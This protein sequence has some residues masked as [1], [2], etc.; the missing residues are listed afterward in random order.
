MRLTIKPYLQSKEL[1]KGPYIYEGKLY[2]EDNILYAR[3]CLTAENLYSNMLKDAFINAM[4]EQ[5]K[6][7]ILLNS[8]YSRT[9]FNISFV[10]KLFGKLATEFSTLDILNTITFGV[11][12]SYVDPL[13]HNIIMCIIDFNRET[14][15]NKRAYKIVKTINEDSE[16]KGKSF[17]LCSLKQ[18]M[19]E[20]NRQHLCK[21]TYILE[22]VNKKV[23]TFWEIIGSIFFWILSF[24]WG[25]ISTFIGL[26]ISIFML[27]SLHRP[28]FYKSSIYFRIGK[29]WGGL[30]FGPFFLVS[31][32]ADMP[33]IYHEWGHGIQN[34]I[35]GPLFPFI[36]QIPSAIRYWYRQF[37]YHRKH[38]CPPTL[39]DDIWFEGWATKIGR[40]H[41]EE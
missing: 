18:K 32:D 34:I 22:K 20:L 27:A 37:K 14:H 38:I 40:T 4:E 3:V 10:Q 29:G 6:L 28:Y 24:T 12:C 25:I 19:D 30:E 2:N 36:I 9:Y 26:I 11:N 13:I 15:N 16:I 35:L 17:N 41:Y 23:W 7:E 21:N 1:E 5:V 8:E 39:Y 31:E 33:I